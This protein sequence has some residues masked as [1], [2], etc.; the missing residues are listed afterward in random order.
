MLRCCLDIILILCLLGT[1]TAVLRQDAGRHEI[2]AWPVGSDYNHFVP[3]GKPQVDVSSRGVPKPSGPD[4]YEVT[5]HAFH[6]QGVLN[7]TLDS[8]QGLSHAFVRAFPYDGS[9]PQKLFSGDLF[10]I[11]AFHQIHCL[12]SILED[13]GLLAAGVPKEELPG[14]HSGVTLT[15]EEHKAHC[16]NYVRQAL[17]C[18]ADSTAEGHIDGD[19]HRVADHGVMHVCNDFDALLAWSKEPERALPKSWRVT[20]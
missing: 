16:F 3:H 14:Y 7:E 1:T 9:G 19:T 15:W 2:T 5:A 17:M 10:E 8:W 18:F 20:D 13:F 12:T 11:A 6:D 4:Q